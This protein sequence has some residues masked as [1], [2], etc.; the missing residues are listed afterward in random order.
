MATCEGTVSYF[1]QTNIYQCLPCFS[2]C[3]ECDGPLISDCTSCKPTY[4]LEGSH[5]VE[6]CGP[7]FF[8]DTNVCTA[9]QRDP[10]LAGYCEDCET[11]ERCTKCI[12]INFIP[13]YFDAVLHTCG[14]ACPSGFF[15]LEGT[16]E[17]GN[18]CYPCSGL[19]KEC[20]GF[21]S[22]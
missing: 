4:Y 7:G 5:C 14:T 20:N 13:Y 10:D 16:A 9:C 3:L 21:L 15:G 18:I 2:T 17:V 12:T 6:T 22:S 8:E 1:P 11:L 19:C